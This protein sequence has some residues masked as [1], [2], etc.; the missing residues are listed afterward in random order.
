MLIIRPKSLDK[1]RFSLL[2]L[3]K[4]VDT[5]RREC[6]SIRQPM[7]CSTITVDS[8]QTKHRKADLLRSEPDLAREQDLLEGNRLS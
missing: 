8:F 1:I 4:S 7:V 3:D 2:Y 5:L 6:L